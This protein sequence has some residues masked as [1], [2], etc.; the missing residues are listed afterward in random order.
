MYLI[1]FS[2]S[3]QVVDYEENTC[4]LQNNKFETMWGS[5]LE[6]TVF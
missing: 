3:Y 4:W 6:F 2:F 1:N 5:D